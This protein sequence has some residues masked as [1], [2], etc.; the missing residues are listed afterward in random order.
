M[1][2]GRCYEKEKVEATFGKESFSFYGSCLGG[3]RVRPGFLVRVIDWGCIRSGGRADE[4]VV[5]G[6]LPAH[7]IL[8]VDTT[9]AKIA[10]SVRPLFLRT[11]LHQL[12]LSGSNRD[13]ACEEVL[14]ALMHAIEGVLQKYAWAPVFAGSGFGPTLR[15]QAPSIGNTGV[16]AATGSY[17]RPTNV[18]P[19]PEL[20]PDGPTDSFHGPSRR[21]LVTDRTPS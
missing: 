1:L 4:R 21:A 12:M 11:Q 10:L 18:C 19:T 20:F 17:R 3:L 5:M 16:E 14:D 15:R 7:D 6:R 8:T 9:R 2:K 13:L